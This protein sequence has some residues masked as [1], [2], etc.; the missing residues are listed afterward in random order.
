MIIFNIYSNCHEFDCNIAGE[1]IN[2]FT[3]PKGK[4]KDKLRKSEG[5]REGG[6]NK[7]EVFYVSVKFV[8]YKPL[9]MYW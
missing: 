3:P 6:E 4:K 8:I 1:K 5:K 2:F 7:I 9:F